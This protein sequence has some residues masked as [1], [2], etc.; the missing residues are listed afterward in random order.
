MSQ[1]YL[2][3]TYSP[4]QELPSLPVYDTAAQQQI[5]PSLTDEWAI[6]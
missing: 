5:R 2:S 6:N 3:E 4:A 1:A